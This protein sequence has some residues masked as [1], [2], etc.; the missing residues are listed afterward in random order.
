MKPLDAPHSLVAQEITT[1]HLR[2]LMESAFEVM[3]SAEISQDGNDLDVYFF[4]DLGHAIGY[5][6]GEIPRRLDLVGLTSLMHE[7]DGKLFAGEVAKALV[8]GKFSAEVRHIGPA[9]QITWWELQGAPI[10]YQEDRARWWVA[11][12]RNI[13]PRK[14]AELQLRSALEEVTRLKAELELENRFLRSE[15]DREHEFQEIIG[16]GPALRAT[17]QLVRRVAPT[18]TP[19]LISGETGTGKELI[20]RAVHQHS[21]RNGRPMAVI[22][23]AAMP[24]T[25][26]ESELFGHEKGAFTG[27]VRRQIGRFEFA[28]GGTLFFDEI[29]ELPLDLQSKLLRVLQS[30]EYQRLGSME[31]QTADVRII[32]A[33]NR[34]LE[35]EVSA[36]RFRSDLYYR[37]GVFPIKLPPLRERKEDIPLLVSY[38]VDKKGTALGKK[39]KRISADTIAALQEYGWPGNV[40]E[41]GN[42][43]ERAIILS[44]GPVFQLHHNLLPSAAE[45]GEASIA[46]VQPLAGP[47]ASNLEEVERLHILRVCEDC[48]WRIKGPDGAAMR[49]GLN[50]STLYFRIKKLGIARPAKSRS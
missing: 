20:A 12:G 46:P 41:L 9:G 24:A 48:Q 2:A 39:F 27:A 19:V 42:I 28:N 26:I 30:G 43:L 47:A 25:L 11:S 17:L 15:Y 1:P 16:S 21:A 35:A 13:S 36:G 31:T 5:A 7:D 3:C 10:G 49:L 38:L 8:T 44:D 50:P 32:A 29:G 37:L 40:R 23:C 14:I 45:H 34:D 4:G 22:N 6:P 33:T 18:S